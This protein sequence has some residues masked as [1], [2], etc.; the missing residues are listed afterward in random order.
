[1]IASRR[2]DLVA[3]TTELI[4]F[5]TT[6]RKVED[7]PRQEVALQEHLGARLRSAGAEVEIWEPDPAD[8]AGH[9]LLPDGLGFEGRPQL[10]ARFK[11][12]GEG[13]SLLLN[14]HID[15]VSAEPRDR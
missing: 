9:P 1:V 2:D 11:G 4:G 3:L 14:G 6:A 12:A 13:G 15:A 8:L 10:V 5:D 7:P